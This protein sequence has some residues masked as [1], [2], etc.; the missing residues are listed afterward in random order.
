MRH[1]RLR[2]T[3]ALS[4]W[5]AANAPTETMGAVE[6]PETSDASAACQASLSSS[7]G[8]ALLVGGLDIHHTEPVPLSCAQPRLGQTMLLSVDQMRMFL[9]TANGFVLRAVFHSQLAGC[10][11]FRTLGPFAVTVPI[12]SIRSWPDL[13]VSHFCLDFADFVLFTCASN[14]PADHVFTSLSFQAITQQG[15]RPRARAR[16]HFSKYS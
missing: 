14:R 5:L 4:G 12:L 15:P 1:A 16:R 10:S 2:T 11:T 6:T 7:I 9:A 8:S 3:A 13:A